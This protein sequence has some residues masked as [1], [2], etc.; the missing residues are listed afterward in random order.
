MP[1]AIADH[2]F[3]DDEVITSDTESSAAELL[4]IDGYCLEAAW[5]VNSP[6]GGFLVLQAS[7]TKKNWFDIPNSEITVSTDDCYMWNVRLVNY[8]YVRL[9]AKI[10]SGSFT[11]TAVLHGK[12]QG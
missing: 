5:T 11:V 9:K 8:R 6:A 3:F 7:N 2:K 4:F 1:R 12:G 10:S